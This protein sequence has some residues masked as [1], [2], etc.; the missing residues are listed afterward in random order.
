M[1]VPKR[2]TT[3]SRSGK[4]RSHIK[5]NIKNI[6]EETPAILRS[7]PQSQYLEWVKQSY[8]IS[9]VS[10]DLA[11]TYVDATGGVIDNLKPRH[12]L[13]WGNIGLSLY[14]SSK[15]STSL[16]NNFFKYYLVFICF[17]SIFFILFLLENFN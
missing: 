5:A 8:R 16:V 4:R 7:I 17:S 14:R 12:L 6:I 1:A 15:N 11:I 2:K 9:E 10:E 13:D 3:K